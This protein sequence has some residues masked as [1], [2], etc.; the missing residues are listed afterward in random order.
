MQKTTHKKH[1]LDVGGE[2]YSLLYQRQLIGQ[3]ELD[4]IRLP[5]QEVIHNFRQGYL[6]AVS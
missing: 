2:R 6:S 4:H 5:G 1:V 3:A